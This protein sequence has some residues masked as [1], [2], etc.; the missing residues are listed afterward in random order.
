LGDPE[1]VQAYAEEHPE[2]ACKGINE[3]VG[4][5]GRGSEISKTS[6]SAGWRTP[7]NSM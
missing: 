1:K 2:Q 3:A 6:R 4:F 7:R 5:D